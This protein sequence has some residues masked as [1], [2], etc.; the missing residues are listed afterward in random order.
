MMITGM[1]TMI[2]LVIAVIL[3]PLFQSMYR[4]YAQTELKSTFDV[5]E[6]VRLIVSIFYYRKI[7]TPNCKLCY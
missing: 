1:S 2:K 7:V 3:I 6:Q 4:L 5:V